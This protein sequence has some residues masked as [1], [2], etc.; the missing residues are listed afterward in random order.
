MEQLDALV[1]ETGLCDMCSADASVGDVWVC[2][3]GPFQTPL[4]PRSLDT[5]RRGSLSL[6]MHEADVG[7][8]PSHGSPPGGTSQRRRRRQE[9]PSQRSRGRIGGPRRSVFNSPPA[10][11]LGDAGCA[12]GGG[13]RIPGNLSVSQTEQFGVSS[14]IGASGS[15][16]VMSSGAGGALPP[17]SSV[18]KAALPLCAGGRSAPRLCWL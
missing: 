16:P 15:A 4:R 11:S 5:R 14:V 12:M 17:P 1:A 3:R 18:A 7:A 10:P 13:Q 9:L 2:A 8:Q 6:G